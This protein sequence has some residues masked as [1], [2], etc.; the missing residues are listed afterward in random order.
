MKRF[1]K[2]TCISNDFEAKVAEELGD[3]IVYATNNVLHT[4]LKI[5]P[6]VKCLPCFSIIADTGKRAE[7]FRVTE[8][9][10]LHDFCR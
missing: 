7:N 1:H 3:N 2:C 4:F 6:V 8:V 9:T 5:F 10:F